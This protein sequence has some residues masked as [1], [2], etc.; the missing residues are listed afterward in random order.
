MHPQLH[1]HARVGV[2]RAGFELT[3]LAVLHGHDAIGVEGADDIGRMSGDNALR[4]VRGEH[5]REAALRAGMQVQLRLVNGENAGATHGEHELRDGAHHLGAL[6]MHVPRVDAQVD[7]FHRVRGVLRQAGVREAH[8]LGAHSARRDLRQLLRNLL[9]QKAQLRRLV[10][11][12]VDGPIRCRDL[13]RAFAQVHARHGGVEVRIARHAQPVQSPQLHVHL[14]LGR[15]RRV[16]GPALGARESPAQC[17]QL[18]VAQRTFPEYAARIAFLH[19]ARG[20][21]A[22]ASVP[23]DEQAHRDAPVHHGVTKNVGF[24]RRESVETAA[25]DER[26]R[27]VA[28][29][30]GAQAQR[31]FLGRRAKQEVE[32]SHNRR[33]SRVVGPDEHEVA[34]HL[35]VDV[36]HEPAMVLD[37]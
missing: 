33:F 24:R 22:A 6:G 16:Y 28:Q 27:L 9:A 11:R 2:E 20:R 3:R 34:A 14:L 13:A 1:A 5:L 30:V 19:E 10:Q 32:A 4:V 35:D 25:H 18:G 37:G 26:R 12:I 23:G 21:D 29:V 36:M 8:V 7:A 15:R 17:A 31:E